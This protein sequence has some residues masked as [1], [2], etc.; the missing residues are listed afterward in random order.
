MTAMSAI[1]HE[2]IKYGIYCA[3]SVVAFMFGVFVC[4]EAEDRKRG[5]KP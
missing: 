3:V 5:R 1:I 4:A 2:L